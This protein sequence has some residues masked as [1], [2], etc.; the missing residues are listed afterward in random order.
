LLLPPAYEVPVGNAIDY[1]VQREDVDPDKIALFGPSM[2]AIIGARVAAHEPRIKAF[3]LDGLVPDVYEAWHAIW[4]AALQNAGPGAFDAV[5]SG[6]EKVSPSLHGAANHFRWMMGVSKPHEMMDVWKTMDVRDTASKIH[7]P[8]LLLYGEAEAAQSNEKVAL[9]CLHYMKELTCPTAVHMFSYEDG[10]AATH[11]Q[12][13][14]IAPLQALVFDWLEK[15]INQKGQLPQQDWESFFEVLLKYLRNN[16]AK[17]EATELA[18]SL[19]VRV[20]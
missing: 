16:E 2:G 20:V 10:W 9:T 18:K 3:I 17:K 1:L 14:A 6:L 7:A 12:V 19:N 13:G 15:T 5:F 4:P 8:V 11:C